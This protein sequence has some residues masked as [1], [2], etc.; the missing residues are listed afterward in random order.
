MTS[1]EIVARA[2]A[3]VGVRFRPQGRSAEQGLDCIGV[4][5]V[6]SGVLNARRDYCL[7]SADRAEADAEFAKHG[8]APMAPEAAGAGDILLVRPG[9]GRLHVVVLTPRGYLHADMRLRRV[10]EVS[11]AV[12]WPI[13]S[14]W[15]H[16]EQEGA[17]RG[18]LSAGGRD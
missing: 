7:R 10:V 15:R 14:A 4:A 5:A 12:P 18:L 3:L 6:A 8:F 2:R 9:A 13:L 16:P 1:E 11:G 17:D